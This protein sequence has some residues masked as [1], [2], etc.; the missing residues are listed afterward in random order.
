ML[1]ASKIKCH[2][3]EGK[4]KRRKNRE[5]DI[6]VDGLQKNLLSSR[7]EFFCSFASSVSK[8]KNCTIDQHPKAAGDRQKYAIP[9]LMN[10]F[11]SK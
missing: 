5:S 6:N 3:I 2:I 4:K 7:K 10:L 11:T 1:Y 9:A 8:C